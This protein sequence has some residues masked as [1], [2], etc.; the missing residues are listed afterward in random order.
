VG[1]KARGFGGGTM[2]TCLDKWLEPLE[3]AEVI[4]ELPMSN[5]HCHQATVRSLDVQHLYHWRISMGFDHVATP[6][7]SWQR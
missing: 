2:K 7:H 6:Y 3:R 4:F 5:Q 1:E